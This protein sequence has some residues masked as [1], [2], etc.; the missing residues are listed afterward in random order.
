MLFE[1]LLP[2]LQILVQIPLLLIHRALH[3]SNFLVNTEVGNLDACSFDFQVHEIYF[4]SLKDFGDCLSIN[5]SPVH[6][7]YTDFHEVSTE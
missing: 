6:L 4:E 3:L 7:N 1:I 2:T 5:Q